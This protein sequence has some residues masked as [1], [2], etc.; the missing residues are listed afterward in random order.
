MVAY[1]TYRVF[2]VHDIWNIFIVVAVKNEQNAA[3]S[4]EYAFIE[5]KQNSDK[6]Q[7]I[8]TKRLSL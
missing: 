8:S 1:T 2:L 5:T 3:N 7:K 4:T 6:C